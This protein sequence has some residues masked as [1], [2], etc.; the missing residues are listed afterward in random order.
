MFDE[1][2]QTIETVRKIIPCVVS[3]VISKFIQD[4]KKLAS[5]TL[6]PLGQ[7]GI[8][9]PEQDLTDDPNNNI[10][11]NLKHR[12]KVGGGSGFIV[13]SDGLI[14][15]NKHVVYDADAQYTVITNDEHEYTGRVITRDPI[16]DVAILKIDVKGLP[17]AEL[18]DS[19]G[20][21]L[22]QTAIAIGN[23]LGVFNNTVS[24]G[25]ISGLS[26]K[27]SASLGKGQVE[28]LRHV[29][30]TDV[31]INQGNSGGPLAN[32]QGKVIAINTAVIYGAQN[33]GFAIPINWA[34][35]DIADLN[36]HGRI[37]RPYIGLRYVTLNKELK[38]QYELDVD[39]GALVIKDHMPGSTAVVKDSPADKADIKENDVILTIDGRKLTEKN[40][41]ADMVDRHKVGDIVELKILRKDKELRTKVKLTERK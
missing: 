41:L 39:Y 8:P 22:G 38:E 24:K 37:I 21:E 35:A 6:N 33:I 23:A 18:G 36:E 4:K 25:I 20:V 5:P 26:R 3:I 31:A 19:D 2:K 7:F 28:N 15:T 11:D 30:Q 34:K 16:N 27:V 29:M 13:S 17:V 9:L 14:V 12:V 40:E 10:P 32:L 1:E